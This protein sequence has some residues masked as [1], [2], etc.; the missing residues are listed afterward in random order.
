MEDGIYKAENGDSTDKT[1]SNVE[2][3]KTESITE[4]I[5]GWGGGG[6]GVTT[7]VAGSIAKGTVETTAG[8]ATKAASWLGHWAGASKFSFGAFG[9][10]LTATTVGASLGL[11]TGQAIIDA[12]QDKF[13]N[14]DG[15]FNEG[16]AGWFKAMTSL[17]GGS[18]GGLHSLWALTVTAVSSLAAWAIY[19]FA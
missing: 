13:T 9:I 10:T 19:E 2:D 17:A 15:T 11:K 7:F 3:A 4:K 16:K 12:N 18:G 8:A 5:L 1:T 14:A 6:V